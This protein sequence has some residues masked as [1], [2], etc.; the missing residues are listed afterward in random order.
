MLNSLIARLV[1]SGRKGGLLNKPK[2]M[3][4]YPRQNSTFAFDVPFT[5]C[6]CCPRFNIRVL[7]CGIELATLEF[8]NATLKFDNKMLVFHAT[9]QLRIFNFMPTIRHAQLSF[10][11]RLS[12]YACFTF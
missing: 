7:Q 11:A 5:F 12:F 2:N 6:V 9:F 10:Y 1:L 3:A 8:H 4:L